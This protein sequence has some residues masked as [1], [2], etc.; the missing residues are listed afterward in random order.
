MPKKNGYFVPSGPTWLQPRVR[1]V[2]APRCWRPFAGWSLEIDEAIFLA[3]APKG[4]ILVKIR[5][6]IFFDDQMFHIESAQK[7]GTITAHVPYGIAQ[8]HN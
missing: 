5:P 3:G 1:R 4:P 6:H 7:V 8:K 2:Q